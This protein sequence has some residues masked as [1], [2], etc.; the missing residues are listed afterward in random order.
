MRLL[1]S[2]LPLAVLLLVTPVSASPKSKAKGGDKEAK[3][4]IHWNA[5]QFI[6]ESEKKYF[7]HLHQL[8][9]DGE[10]AE[11]YWD[12]DGRHLVFQRTGVDGDGLTTGCD[13]IYRIDIV[14]G[15]TELISTGDGRTTCSFAIPE[16]TKVLFA[17]THANS[18]DCPPKPDM[19][20]G[21]VWPIYPGYDIY[22]RD[23]AT[24]TLA[25][26]VHHTGYDAEAT[27]DPSGTWM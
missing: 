13:Q 12:R 8:T 5:D 2:C 9:F 20:Q 22:T 16:T 15:E 27:T 24:Q 6:L 25:P 18:A 4:A 26:L 10:N 17:S 7:K 14:T 3:E 19:S 23:L 21:Y 1:S 11:A